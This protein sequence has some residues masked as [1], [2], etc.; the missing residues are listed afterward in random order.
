LMS[1]RTVS[2]KSNRAGFL[3][4]AVF[5]GFLAY[6]VHKDVALPKPVF[7]GGAL[8]G[9]LFLFVQSLS[10][11]V[12]A[13]SVMVCYLPF[14]KV[15]VGDFG[16]AFKALNLTNILMVL[17]L[18][19]MAA[20][21]G[22]GRRLFER[23]ALN[24]PILL[25]A[26]WAML[27]FVKGVLFFGVYLEP[28]EFFAEVK[29]WVTPLLIFYLG[30]NAFDKKEE[31]K[32]VIKLVM[33]VVGLV[34]LMAAIDYMNVGSGTSFENSRIGGISD[35]PNQLAGFFV[36]YMFLY[37]GFFLVYF[38]MARMWLILLPM[39]VA[40]RGLMVTFSRGGYLAFA[41]G[42][43]A[44]SFIRSK[45]L[46]FFVILCAVGLLLNPRFLPGG[47]R[48]R[49]GM[50]I[51]STSDVYE[52]DLEEQLEGS[53]ATRIE[54]WKTAMVMIR[55]KPVFG[56]GYGTFPVV[57]AGYNPQLGAWDAHNS[58]IIIAAEMGIPA[59]ILFLTILFVFFRESLWLYRYAED[60]FFRATGLGLCAGIAALMVVNMFGSRM[61]SLEI[62]GYFW[63]LAGI[64]LKM[65]RIEERNKEASRSSAP[66]R[67]ASRKPF[68]PEPSK[69]RRPSGYINPA[70]GLP[71]KRS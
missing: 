11:P 40:F 32:N 21:L 64:A 23:N 12:A 70:T 25:Y 54:I 2:T 49:M 7:W 68:R 56:F 14:S 66:S 26:L 52:G 67:P 29:R 13:F 24:V 3:V 34:G 44:I 4:G 9:G 22:Q 53:S 35:Q 46:F 5:I 51:Q 69:P 27:S 19:G 16:G 42:G 6:I 57:L 31:L 18:I 30:F 8:L 20:R 38:P 15:L 28:L 60:K 61:N 37:A 50:T 33:V 47:I 65:K 59:L 17:V 45:V 55:D 58:Y 63:M 36:N 39:L 43:L 10:S 48:Y 71:W 62:S 41:A 1:N